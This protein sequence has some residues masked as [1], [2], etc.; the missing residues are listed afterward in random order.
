MVFFARNHP[1]LAPYLTVADA[2]RAIRFYESAFGARAIRCM[3]AS[4]GQR[5]RHAEI[6]INGGLVMLAD[7][8]DEDRGT[9]APAAGGTV[10]VSIS[11]ELNDAAAVDRMYGR[12][13]ANGAAPEMA[14]ADTFWGSRTAAFRDP[15][16]HRWMLNAIRA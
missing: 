12:A 13:I 6:E 2:D 8:F 4:D 1:P 16:G 15:F 14:P 9:R 5:L 11:L 3:K 10:P 7:E